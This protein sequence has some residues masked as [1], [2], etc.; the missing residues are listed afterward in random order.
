MTGRKQGG[1]LRRVTRRGPLWRATVAVGI[2]VLSSAAFLLDRRNA[3]RVDCAFEFETFDGVD[4]RIDSGD[5]A[6]PA[7]VR[8]PDP[9]EVGRRSV[10]GATRRRPT[11]RPPGLAGVRA[12]LAGPTRDRRVFPD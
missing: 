3:K 9:D 6:L 2:G 5:E 8:A 4:V 1:I 12:G 11:H 10:G 7:A